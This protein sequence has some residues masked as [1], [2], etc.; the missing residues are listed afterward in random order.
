[1]PSTSSSVESFRPVGLKL[2]CTL[3]SPRGRGALKN[4]GAWVP[5]PQDSDTVSL[6]YVLSI[7][8]FKRSPG[9]SSEQ[10]GWDPL[11]SC[12][13]SWLQTQFSSSH[14]NKHMLNICYVWVTV[15]FVET[16]VVWLGGRGKEESV[17]LPVEQVLRLTPRIIFTALTS[18]GKTLSLHC[19][20]CPQSV[21]AS[22]ATIVSSSRLLGSLALLLKRKVRWESVKVA[23]NFWCPGPLCSNVGKHQQDVTCHSNRDVRSPA[24]KGGK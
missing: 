18:L 4:A 13:C 3:K 8:T 20:L 2:N 1:M 16:D 11:Y 23:P 12:L 6:G 17:K 19:G 24:A 9:G 22:R 5:L 15:G 21:R 14:V 10:L 7:G